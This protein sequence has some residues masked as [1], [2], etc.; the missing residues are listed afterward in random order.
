MDVRCGDLVGAYVKDT[1]IVGVC[2][3]YVLCFMF[4]LI[5]PVV[6]HHR[7]IVIH[8]VVTSTCT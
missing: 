3:L 8:F 5:A 4:Y 7:V 2:V 6:P 1:A